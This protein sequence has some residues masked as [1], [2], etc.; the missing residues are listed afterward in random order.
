MTIKKNVYVTIDSKTRMVDLPDNFLGLIGENLQGYVIFKFK[1]MFVDGIPRVE[2]EKDGQK[3]V[4]SEVAKEDETYK[5]LIKSS[6]LTTNLLNMQLILTEQQQGQEIPI[7]KSKQFHVVVAESINA[8]V[9]I[10]EEYDTWMDIANQKI[11]DINN[12]IQEVENLNVTGERVEDGVEITFTDK[13]GNETTEKVNDGEKGEKGDDYVITQKDYQNIADIVETDIAPTL[14]AETTAR[15]N[16]DNSLQGQI[17]AI[18]SSSDVVDIVGTY[19]ELQNYDTSKLTEDD[20]VKVLS[21]STHNNALSYYRWHLNEWVYIGSEGPFYTKSETMALLDTK[22]STSD[23]LTKMDKSNPTGTGKLQINGAVVGIKTVAIGD[24]AT[25]YGNNS[26][27]EGLSSNYALN[28]TDDN[29]IASAVNEENPVSTQLLADW[30]TDKFSLAGGVGSHVEGTNSL[31]LGKNSH[32]EGN[33]TIAE[34]HSSHTEGTGSHTKG[35]YAH[36]GGLETYAGNQGAFAHGQRVRATGHNSI[37]M[38]YNESNF[39][40]NN[41]TGVRSVAIGY[42]TKATAEDSYALGKRLI[43]SAISQ[44]VVGKYNE[45]DLNSLFVVGNG[46]GTSSR[47]NAFY[48]SADGK[49]YIDGTLS[50]NDDEKVLIDLKYLREHLD[51]YFPIGKYLNNATAVNNARDAGLYNVKFKYDL[52]DGDSCYGEMLVIPYVSQSGGNRVDYGAQ[53]FFPNGDETNKNCFWYRTINRNTWNSW[54]KVDPSSYLTSSSLTDYVKNTDYATSSKGGVL[55][56][57]NGLGTGVSN[58]GVLVGIDKTYSQYNSAYNDLFISKG[59][60]ENVITGKGLVSNTNYPTYDNAGVV[61]RANQ[62]DVNN[63]N[64]QPYCSTVA[65]DNYPS[66]NNSAFISKGTLENVITGKE[67][68]SSNDVKN[69]VVSTDEDKPLSANMGKELNDRI[70]NLA[71]IG[72]YLAMWD[73][74]T[75]LPTTDPVTMPYTYTTGDYYVISNVGATNYMPNGSS[76][77]G[78]ASSTQ[79]SGTETLNVGDFFYYDGTVWTMLKNTGKTVYFA[80]IAGNPTDN[81]NLASALNGKVGFTDYATANTGGVIKVFSQHSYN[82]NSY[83]ALYPSTKNYTDYQSMGNDAFIGKGTLENVLGARFVTLTQAQYDA[84]VS[85]GTVDANTYYF[86]EEE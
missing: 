71:S 81:S 64:G 62:F 7:F 79:Y 39:N 44:F 74:T 22:A 52:G 51:D 20:V 40:S 63:T 3:Y 66:L 36:A 73:C 21:D 69:N 5:M 16:A 17:D 56:I 10:P 29:V 15:Q 45:E 41:A 60:L 85:G 80:N 1:D 49:A 58:Y 67:L 24:K 8:T 18:T 12:A 82:V 65:Y 46:Q 26:V 50:S 77:S 2:V 35:N 68:L 25:A 53:L 43:A 86:I 42:E 57:D 48:I 4:I 61:K 55:K 32:A 38:G 59:T 23:L 28:I 83:G 33:G 47:N 84:L 37:A 34:G 70:Q 19:T 13:L 30:E 11:I 31:A 54:V 6:L 78:T 27:A 75:G 72:K 76:Y 9:E 14:E